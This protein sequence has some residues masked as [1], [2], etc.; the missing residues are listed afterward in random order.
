VT[1][2]NEVTTVQRAWILCSFIYE[3]DMMA[4]LHLSSHIPGSGVR[5]KLPLPGICGQVK[6]IVRIKDY[7]GIYR[8]LSYMNKDEGSEVNHCCQV[9]ANFSA[10]VTKFIHHIF[11]YKFC[12]FEFCLLVS[13]VMYNICYIE[14]LLHINV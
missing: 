11:L 13:F 9:F 7:R 6:G 1:K 5:H 3:S 12:Y 2:I 8:L 14:T 10:S 4:L